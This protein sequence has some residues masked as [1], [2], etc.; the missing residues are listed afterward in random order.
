[1]QRQVH[2]T[3]PLSRVILGKSV[4]ILLRFSNLIKLQIESSKNLQLFCNAIKKISVFLHL[5]FYWTKKNVMLIQV[6]KFLSQIYFGS[7]REKGKTSKSIKNPARFDRCRWWITR[8]RLDSNSSF[9]TFNHMEIERRR[10]VTWQRHR[11]KIIESSVCNLLVKGTCLLL[12][13]FSGREFLPS[14]LTHRWHH[15]LLLLAR[16]WKLIMRGGPLKRLHD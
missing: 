14:S 9:F 2:I 16:I 1:M 5:V 7:D 8:V 11:F 10:C 3:V 12:K 15:T 4:K 13:H 6:A